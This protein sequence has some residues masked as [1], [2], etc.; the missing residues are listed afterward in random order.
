MRPNTTLEKHFLMEGQRPKEVRP[1]LPF[2]IPICC[3]AAAVWMGPTCW[4]QRKPRAASF[5]QDPHP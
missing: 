1:P 3:M 5:H 2:S 4:G